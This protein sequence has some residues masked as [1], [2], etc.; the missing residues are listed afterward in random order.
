LNTAHTPNSL[1]EYWQLAYTNNTSN[2]YIDRQH[3]HTRTD[4]CSTSYRYTFTCAR[5]TAFTVVID[6]MAIDALHEEPK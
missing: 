5:M 1:K 6:I 4:W 3:L 2:T